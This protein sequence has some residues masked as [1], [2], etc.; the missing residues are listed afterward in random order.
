MLHNFDV[1]FRSMYFNSGRASAVN[2]HIDLSYGLD[3]AL[4]LFGDI[5]SNFSVNRL[6]NQ[7]KSGVA[8]EKSPPIPI[9]D[10]CLDRKLTSLPPLVN[11]T[12]RAAGYREVHVAEA[13]MI[14][15]PAAP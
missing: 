15:Q 14:K 6:S 8:W 11:Q 13:I 7:M 3:T 9:C 12:Q 2:Q 4:A 5:S 10:V 1:A